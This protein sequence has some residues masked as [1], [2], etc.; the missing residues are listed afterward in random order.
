MARRDGRGLLV[1]I[2]LVAVLLVGC[3]SRGSVRNSRVRCKAR[4]GEGTCEGT[5]GSVQGDYTYS[6]ED[7]DRAP[8]TAVWLDLD[9]SITTGALRVTLD[10]D[11]GEEVVMVAKP[12]ES[13][14]YAGEVATD[15]MGHVSIGMA[16]PEG[17][18]AEGVAFRAAWELQ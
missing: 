6:I 12:G 11:D 1:G 4:M 13:V 7:V 14:A 18:V 5:F 3:E 8:G 16:V 17:E 9:V 2:V 15:A 10:V